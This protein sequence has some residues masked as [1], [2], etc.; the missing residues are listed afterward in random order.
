MLMRSAV[1]QV[2]VIL[3]FNV[4]VTCG[5]VVLRLIIFVYEYV[6]PPSTPIENID[7]EPAFQLTN[8]K[9]VMKVSVLRI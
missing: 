5:F 9:V 2:I 3:R 7:Y 6:F 1:R 8:M 4:I